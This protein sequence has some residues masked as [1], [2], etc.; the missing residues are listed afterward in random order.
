[1]TDPIRIASRATGHISALTDGILWPDGIPLPVGVS[2]TRA[3][4]KNGNACAQVSICVCIVCGVKEKYVCD[5]TV[6]RQGGYGGGR[7]GEM[8]R[9]RGRERGRR[10]EGSSGRRVRVSSWDGRRYNV[11]ST[12]K[13]QEK[14]NIVYERQGKVRIIKPKDKVYMYVYVWV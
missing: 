11:V 1:M 8:R 4:R 13:H 7:G 3:R 9:P 10:G 6:P 5:A 14:Y 12:S 2:I